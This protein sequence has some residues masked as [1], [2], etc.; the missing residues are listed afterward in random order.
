MSVAD[1]FK[2]TGIPGELMLMTLLVTGEDVWDSFADGYPSLTVLDVHS[3][4]GATW[5]AWFNVEAPALLV[6]EEVCITDLAE[7]VDMLDV[8]YKESPPE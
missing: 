4:E 5:A 1:D 3:L 2:S 8:Y 7:L 6:T